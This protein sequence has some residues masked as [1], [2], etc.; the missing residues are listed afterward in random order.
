MALANAQAWG[1]LL[2][3]TGCAPGQPARDDAPDATD[4]LGADTDRPSLTCDARVVTFEPEGPTL[5]PMAEALTVRFDA[6][7]PPSAWDV[8]VVLLSIDEGGAVDPDA[9]PRELEGDATLSDD[10]RSATWTPLAPLPA[11][12]QLRLT[13]RACDQEASTEWTT[14]PSPVQPSDLDGR[15]WLI[16]APDLQVI[17][18]AASPLLVSVLPELRIRLTADVDHGDVTLDASMSSRGG[19]L[20]DV[21]FGAIDLYGNPSFRAGPVDFA[22]EDAPERAPL[23]S[24]LSA[25]LSGTFVHGG[26]DIRDLALTALLDTR[27]APPMPGPVDL[28]AIS[29]DLGEPCAPCPDGAARC[30]PVLIVQPL[31]RGADDESGGGCGAP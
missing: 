12:A 8:Q 6:P 4:A 25:T 31:A 2:A 30:L 28:C 24:L 20:D 23:V 17:S 21:D 14:A 13:A 11:A 15:S 19:C 29:A 3:L 18:P 7:V 9:V 26:A 1:V 27:T 16:A 10:R 5:S 22:P